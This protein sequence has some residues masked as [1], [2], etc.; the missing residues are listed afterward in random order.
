ML[1]GRGVVQ[2]DKGKSIDGLVEDREI[3]PILLRERINQHDQTFTGKRL[4]ATGCAGG[5]LYVSFRLL[6][7][8]RE[9]TFQK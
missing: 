5:R 6:Q 7:C 1:S 9:Q 4:V 2:I 3:R 8:A